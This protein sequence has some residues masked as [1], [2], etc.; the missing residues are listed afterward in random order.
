[1]A[2]LSLQ[3]LQVEFSAN[4]Q[5]TVAVRDVSFDIH[6]GE[7]FALVG[8]SGS[9]KTVTALSI[10]R[11]LPDAKT[12]GRVIWSPDSTAPGTS[13]IDLV[14]ANMPTLRAIRGAEIG[15]IFQE[16]MS[17]LNP[18]FSVGDQIAEVLEVHQG[19]SKKAAFA[20]AVELLDRTGVDE[21][22]RRAQAFPHQL[23]GGQR[24][25]VLIAMAL[26]CGPRL[27]IADEPT[28]ALDVTIR[29]QV[30]ELLLQL[31]REDGMAILLITHDLPL[32]ARFAQRVGVM[33]SGRLVELNTTA[34]LFARP[35]HEYTQRLLA[36]RP[37]RMVA[38]AA[39]GAELLRT[40]QLRC[41]F[42]I[43]MGW[44]KKRQFVAVEEASLS[45]AQGETLG[46]VGESGSGK[47]TLAL[48][49]L[50][51]SSAA[52]TGQIRFDQTNLGELNSAEMRRQRR[53]MQIVFQDPFSALSPRMTIGQILE[54]GLKL[55]FTE[56]SRHERQDRIAEMLQ[57]VGLPASSVGRY[58]HEFSGGQRQRI[59]IARA[60]ILQPD[61]I[62]LDE[63]TSA[64][65]V[66]IQQQVL[67][68]L[69]RLQRRHRMAYLLI[70]H[71]L[72][73]IRAM[74]HRVMVM[75]QGRVVE[76]GSTTEVLDHPRTPYT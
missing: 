22:Q 27:L 39:S 6:A 44:W 2:L 47:T 38:D 67:E 56:L 5:S 75:H 37:Q 25:R 58:P 50:R 59:A 10:L 32:V 8:E 11:L 34:E 66:S 40:E 73:V 60:V 13:G 76:S 69:V 30:L 36:S 15:M 68:L 26:A 45:V 7:R 72:A 3:N 62:V 57:E 23:S 1:M 48:A 31:Q 24:Q 19:L 70:T 61:L 65:D 49:L 12:S 54:E 74:A 18:L 53:R 20:R 35:Q 52:V 43:P 9:G 42:S 21:P 14:G 28:T 4:D 41:E 63:P 51:L 55:H 29:E 64:L 17:A 71:D 16:P 33:Q 46:I